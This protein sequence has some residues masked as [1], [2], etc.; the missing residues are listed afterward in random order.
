LIRIRSS[1]AWHWKECPGKY[2][3]IRSGP[4]RLAQLAVLPGRP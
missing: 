2:A 4:E 3:M 1:G